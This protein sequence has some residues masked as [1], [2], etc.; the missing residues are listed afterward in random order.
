MELTKNPSFVRTFPLGGYAY[1]SHCHGVYCHGVYYLGGL[2][3]PNSNNRARK[4]ADQKNHY[5]SLNPMV[6]QITD[7]AV[8]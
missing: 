1:H 6:L 3:G 5:R 7:T 4:Q 2:L 8:R